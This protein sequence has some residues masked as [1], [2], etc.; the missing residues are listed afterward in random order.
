MQLKTCSLLRPI[1]PFIWSWTCADWIG[2]QLA[3]N[4][5]INPVN[6]RRLFAIIGR[7]PARV[8]PLARADHAVNRDIV[9]ALAGC[10]VRAEAEL[11]RLGC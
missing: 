1:M 4:R 9:L 10:S 2:P 5:V 7:P 11:K 3:K 6:G 8:L